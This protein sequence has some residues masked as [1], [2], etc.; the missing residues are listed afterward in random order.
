MLNSL[1]KKKKHINE[2]IGV[3]GY[4]HSKESAL[5][6]GCTSHAPESPPA[7]SM[8][9]REHWRQFVPKDNTNL[10]WTLI[11]QRLF[12]NTSYVNVKEKGR[13]YMAGEEQQ[14][15]KGQE[16]LEHKTCG[17]WTICKPLSTYFLI[18]LTSLKPCFHTDP[19]EVFLLHTQ[20][21]FSKPQC[22]HCTCLILSGCLLSRFTSCCTEQYR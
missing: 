12:G 11:L 16:N 15:K 5:C 4:I 20:R 21:S 1:A 18:T 17:K 13:Q 6:D 22:W 3:R 2:H 7:P 10:P 14:Q 19:C 9:G 8:P